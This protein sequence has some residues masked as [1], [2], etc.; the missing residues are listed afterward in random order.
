VSIDPLPRRRVT[1][2]AVATVLLFVAHLGLFAIGFFIVAA[3][4]MSTDDCG[5]RACGDAAWLK[6]AFL[7]HV[8]AGFALVVADFLIARTRLAD[9]RIAFVVPLTCCLLEVGLCTAAVA[10]AAHSGPV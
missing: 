6:W 3:L 2:D 5:H 7:V 1:G 9:D 10:L 4:G 8:C